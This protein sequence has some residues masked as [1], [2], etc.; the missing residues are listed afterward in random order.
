MPEGEGGGGERC[1]RKRERGKE[2]R[3]VRGVA[4]RRAVRTPGIKESALTVIAAPDATKSTLANSSTT[5][6]LVYIVTFGQM[7]RVEA[8]S[9][10]FT[11]RRGGF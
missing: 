6:E 8:M 3:R 2:K 5:K 9:V 4:E 7:H 10:V 1:K 11:P